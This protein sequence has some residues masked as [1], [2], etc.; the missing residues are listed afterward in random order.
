MEFESL[1]GVLIWIFAGG[2]AVLLA[3]Y[4]EA[5]LLENWGAWHGFPL[6]VKKSFPIIMAGVFGISAQLLVINELLVAVPPALSVVLLSALNWI[7]S[8]KGYISTKKNNYALATKNGAS[9][10]SPETVFSADG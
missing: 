4:V 10:L 8:Q 1:E 5:F 6:W 7:F 2:G 3:G 9:A